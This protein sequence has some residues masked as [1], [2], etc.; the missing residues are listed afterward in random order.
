MR[1]EGRDEAAD[2]AREEVV[3][4]SRLLSALV[5][6]REMKKISL[7]LFVIAAGRRVEE[8]EKEGAWRVAMTRATCSSAARKVRISTVLSR[9]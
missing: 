4:I 8:E 9:T 6:I 7:F 2:E 1:S 3:D 5:R